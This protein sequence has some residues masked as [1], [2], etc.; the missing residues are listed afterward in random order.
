MYNITRWHQ[1]F[2][3]LKSFI[4]ILP[5]FHAIIRVYS[6]LC[7]IA[8]SKCRRILFY[9]LQYLISRYIQTFIKGRQCGCWQTISWWTTIYSVII[10]S[11]YLISQWTYFPQGEIMSLLTPIQYHDGHLYIYLYFYRSIWLADKHTFVK[12]R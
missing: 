4:Y 12:G 1:H 5:F 2:F 10:L 8:Y 9:Y 3:F 6:R 11:E 7:L